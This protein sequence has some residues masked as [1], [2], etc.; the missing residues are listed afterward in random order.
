MSAKRRA[1]MRLT[2][3]AATAGVLMWTGA[4]SATPAHAVVPAPAWEV[5]VVAQP[6]TFSTTHTGACQENPEAQLNVT[7]PCDGYTITVR[8]SGSVASTEPITITD[9]LP[10]E[11]ITPVHVAGVELQAGAFT[12]KPIEC[13]EAPLTLTPSCT[14]GEPVPPDAVLVMQVNVVTTGE[15]APVV[16]SASVS[17]GGA[18]AAT[19]STTNGLDGE[20]TP[21]GLADYALT[22]KGPDGLADVQAGDHPYETTAHVAFT[23]KLAREALGE[24]GDR[25]VEEPRDIVAYLPTGLVGNT[26]AV[27]QC[28]ESALLLSTFQSSC[29]KASVIGV[30]TV[31]LHGKLLSSGVTAAATSLIYNITPEAGVPAEFGFTYQGLPVFIY[32]RVVWHGNGYKLRVSSTGLPE[33]GVLDLSL[34]FFGDPSAKSHSGASAKAFMRNPTSCSPEPARSTLEVDSF[35]EPRLWQAAESSTYPQLEGCNMLQFDPTIAVTPETGHADQ[36]SGYEVDVNVPQ[37]TEMPGF[38]GTPDVKDATVSFPAG[39]SLSPSAATGL[40]GCPEE[41]PEGI[42]FPHG[43]AHP[44]EAGPGEEIGPDGL[45]RISTGHC[46]SASLIGAA[47]AVTPL[48]AAPL[49]GHA[50]V[51]Q[52]LCGGAG[53]PIC[54]QASASN[55]DLF[56]LY[57]EL[58][59]AG[60]IVK[61]KGILAVDPVTGRLTAHFSENPQLPFEAIKLRLDGGPRAP[62]ANPQSCGTFTT[63]TDIVPWST[64]I[65]PD[66]MPSSPIEV[67][68]CVTPM[69]FSPGF[70]AGTVTPTANGFSPFTL[71][72]SRRDGEQ[73]L[74]SATVTTPAGVLGMLS[75]VE[76]CHEPQAAQGRC[77]PESLIGHAHVAAG[78]GSHPLWVS[79]EVF[80]TG[81]YRGAPFGLTILTH[82]QAG[83]FNLG[84]VIVRAA[85]QVNPHTSALTVASDALPQIVDGVPLRLKTINVTIDRPG[86]IFNPTS[87]MRQQ[88]SGAIAGTTPSGAVGATTA[89]STPFAVAGCGS[90]SFTPRF[91][92]LAQA[93]TSKANGAYVHVKVTSVPGQAN[94]AKVKVE[95]PK[96]L[97]SRLTTLQKACPDGTFNRNPASCPAGSVVGAAVAVTPVLKSQLTGPAYLVSH[98]GA[99]FPDLVVVLQG[100]GITLDLVGNTDIRKGITTSTFDAL[101]DAP[102]STFDLVLPNG[103]HSVLGANLPLRAKGSLCRQTLAMPTMIIGQNGAIVRQTTKVAVSGCPKKGRRSRSTKSHRRHGA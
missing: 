87:C 77:G 26:Q 58:S 82:A 95:L 75:R 33:E 99:A 1:R 15:H 2:I 83:P 5:H 44:D 80:L 100:E 14:Y 55:G 43:T 60:V 84:D 13:S 53:Q 61:L 37:A 93:K 50:Y 69:P 32:A 8:N 28:P 86:F 79:G 19:A 62:L 74:A 67:G 65:T 46:P 40:L 39:L 90:L 29:P 16:N 17:G 96:Q 51:G 34:T 68:G 70:A 7:R 52:P 97:P 102:I 24:L 103:A 98:A 4:M 91:T 72:V 101:P 48:L 78:A 63:T 31:N 36:P 6:S 20:A 35:Q 42:G 3:T 18:P 22:A 73:N 85:I 81:P 11:A 27:E 45:S 57:L 41:G 25:P 92:V 94:I 71:T 59:G 12:P 23:S 38:A 10:T 54:T 47:E 56:R 66:A 88:V 30:A 64:P 76:L 21:F 9:Q 89:V 49:V